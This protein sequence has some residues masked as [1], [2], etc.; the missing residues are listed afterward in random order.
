MPSAN[1]LDVLAR[2]LNR[3]AGLAYSAGAGQRHQPVLGHQIPYLGD[4]RFA[5]YKAGELHWK[6]L[7]NNSFSDAQRKKVVDQIWMA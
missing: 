5:S 7:G 2:D 6:A 3:H 1:S 4:I